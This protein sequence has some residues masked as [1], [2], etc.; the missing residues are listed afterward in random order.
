MAE[1]TYSGLIAQVIENQRAAVA[2]LASDK[3]DLADAITSKGVNTPISTPVGDMASKVRAIKLGA[4]I[5]NGIVHVSG[6]AKTIE[7]PCSFVPTLL[8]MYYKGSPND[9]SVQGSGWN[10]YAQSGTEY[11]ASFVESAGGSL[12]G[13]EAAGTAS[14]I[15]LD[16]GVITVEAPT[17]L[18]NSLTG[19][20]AS[21]F[22]GGYSTYKAQWRWY[23]I[24]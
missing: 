11:V 6:S 23:A 17:Y 19:S 12:G 4:S 2:K 15:I 20:K 22:R 18:Y 1:T 8:I 9:A 5:A 10:I 3:A 21:Y 24:K 14:K 13:G 16:N 7:I